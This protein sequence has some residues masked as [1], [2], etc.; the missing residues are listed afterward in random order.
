M[1]VAVGRLHFDDAFA[2]F[3]HRYVEGA[4]AEVVDDDRFVLLLVE[5]VGE[6]G[7]SRLVDDPKHVEAGNLSGVLGGLPL[8]IVEVRGHGDD[9]VG[10]FLTEIVLSCRL[11]LLKHHRRDLGGRIL[12]APHVDPR[13][14]IAGLDDRVRHPRDLLRHFSVLA[15]HEA[16]DREHGAFGI[17]DSLT[18]GDLADQPF[19]VLTEGDDRGG[20]ARTFLVHDD[21]RLPAFHHGHDRVRGPQ[22]DSDDLAHLVLFSRCKES[23]GS[24]EFMS[25]I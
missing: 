5:T 23:Y 12:L 8:R 24:Y 10:D 19:P 3:K 1:R 14:A 9:R 2:D 7:R 6:R 18:L 11:Q 25:S 22:I 13:I 15:P 4:A 21:G 20:R 16:L 17:G